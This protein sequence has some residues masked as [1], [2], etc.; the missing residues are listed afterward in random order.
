MSVWWLTYQQSVFKRYHSDKNISESF[1]YMM[2]AKINWHRCGTK[3]RRCHPMYCD[4]VVDRITWYNFVHYA[5]TSY[6]SSVYCI[7]CMQCRYAKSSMTRVYFWLWMSKK[8]QVVLLGTDLPQ[9][10]QFWWIYL[11]AICTEWSPTMNEY[12]N[13]LINWNCWLRATVVVVHMLYACQNMKYGF[14]TAG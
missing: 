4:S 1:T 10:N 11:P 3:L 8:S 2:A 6:N 5:V 12:G 13:E 9:I 14:I 7:I